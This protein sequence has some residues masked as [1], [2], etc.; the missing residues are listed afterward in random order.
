MK[1]NERWFLQGML[2]AAMAAALA[3]CQHREVAPS[4]P[5]PVQVTTL[6][7]EPITSE[8]RFGATVR[9]Q[10]R[11]ELSFKVAGTVM[12]LLQMPG[13]DGTSRDVQEGDTVTSDPKRPLA[14]LDDSDY[15]RRLSTVEERLAQAQAKERAAMAGVTAVRATFGRIKA[16]RERDSVPQQTYDD[17]LAKK[18]SAEA[19]LD[20]ARR[21]V[22]AATVALRQAEDDVKN[23]RLVPPIAA[24]VVSRKSV[25]GGE[26]VQAGQPVFQVMDLAR[27]RVAFGVSD[28]KVGHFK[29]GQSVDVAADAFPGE[30]FVGQ[31]TKI[32]PAA[33]LKTRTFEVEMTIAEPKGLKPGMVVTILVGRRETVLLIPM[34]AV[35]RG[36]T[37]GE[38]FVYTVVDE[39]GR[40]VARRR[41]VRFDGVYDNRL[42]LVSGGECRVGSGDVIV[43]SGSFRLTEGQV[44]RVLDVHEPELQ[45]GA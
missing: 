6:K 21:G 14:Q 31:I 33:D 25:E 5:I 3:G 1:R 22:G 13:L 10:Q 29:I 20:A 39:N 7:P 35:H 41:R 36:E 4:P 37:E 44:V 17:T 34:T 40:Q 38:C 30:R 12:S 19:E 42:R 23:C 8:T 2:A 45:I 9:E 26:R 18:D 32:V 15:K 24:A 11:I 27:V 16:L 43:V 28:T